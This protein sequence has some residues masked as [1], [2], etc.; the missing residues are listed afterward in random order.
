MNNTFEEHWIRKGN[1]TVC[2]WCGKEINKGGLHGMFLKNQMTDE[3]WERRFCQCSFKRCL[4]CGKE[5]D[6]TKFQEYCEEHKKVW[7][8]IIKG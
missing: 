3:E 5:L 2:K 4:K 6:S 7:D 8:K 1:I